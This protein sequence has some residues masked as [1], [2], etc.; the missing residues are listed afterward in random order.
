MIKGPLQLNWGRGPW[1]GLRRL[2]LSSSRH[3]PGAAG[4]QFNITKSSAGIE[5][6]EWFQLGVNKKTECQAGGQVL[7]RKWV[8]NDAGQDRYMISR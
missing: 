1:T 5:G 7:W 3:L 6:Q 8:W 4:T 2:L